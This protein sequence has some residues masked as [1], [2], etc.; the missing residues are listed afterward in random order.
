MLDF[1]LQNIIEKDPRLL[2]FATKLANCEIASKLELDVIKGSLKD[3]ELNL[4]T[5][6][7]EVEAA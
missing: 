3:F 4:G 6:K 5:I 1:M 2:S 7:R